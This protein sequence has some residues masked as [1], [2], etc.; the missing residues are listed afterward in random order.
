M[1]LYE[2]NTMEGITFVMVLKS[3]MSL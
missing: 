2:V 3:F 1:T